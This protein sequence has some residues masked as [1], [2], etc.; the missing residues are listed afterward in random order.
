MTNKAKQST[1]IVDSEKFGAPLST[2]TTVKTP[3]S[4]IQKRPDIAAIISKAVDA[5]LPTEQ[6]AIVACGPDSMMSV[7]RKSVAKNIR[8]DGPTVEFYNEH[9]G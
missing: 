5:T 3:Y 6:I 7:V 8:P 4:I 1:Q 2:S 9:F